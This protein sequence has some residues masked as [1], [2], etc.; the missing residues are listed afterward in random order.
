MISSVSLFAKALGY[1]FIGRIL[2][3]VEISIIFTYLTGQP[4]PL[5]SLMLATLTSALNFVFAFIPG[6]LGI[7]ESFYAGFFY[8]YGQKPSLG[9]AMQLIRRLRALFWI[10]VG[11]IL[12][13]RE[14]RV[15]AES[16]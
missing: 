7:L 16:A 14:K 1:H 13:N 11:V 8:F 4:Y 6:A 10:C 2:G 12:L 9:V 15:R 5:L 3:V